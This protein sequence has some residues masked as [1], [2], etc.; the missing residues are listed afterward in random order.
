MPSRRSNPDELFLASRR[1]AKPEP[2]LLE[3]YEF[4][5]GVSQLNSVKITAVSISLR[6][7]PHHMKFASRSLATISLAVFALF[8]HTASA[9][10]PAAPGRG[11]GPVNRPPDPRVQQRKYHFSDTEE[12]PY[13]LYVA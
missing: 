7:E 1:Y 9:Q 8:L 3:R 13:A 4:N 10:P 11:R 6:Q 5:I 2:I 12:L